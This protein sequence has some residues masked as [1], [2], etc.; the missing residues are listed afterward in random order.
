MVDISGYKAPKYDKNKIKYPDLG[1]SWAPVP[2][3]AQYPVP[4]PQSQEVIENM[5]FEDNSASLEAEDMPHLLN[6]DDLND[7][8]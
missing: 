4:K 5:D 7:L 6:Q 1:S 3:S 8:I 2:H